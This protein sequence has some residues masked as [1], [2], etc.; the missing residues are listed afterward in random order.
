MWALGATLYQMLVGQ[1]PF[2]GGSHEE[3]VANALALNYA[4]PD[5]LS[6]EARQL[7]DSTLQVLPSDRA[8]LD[9]L[10]KDP[11][12]IAEA[13][14]PPDAPSVLVECDVA[15]SQPKAAV[16]TCHLARARQIAV[17]A[18]YAVLLVGALMYGAAQD[19]GGIELDATS[20]PDLRS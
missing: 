17:Y 2:V 11:W 5:T 13:P 3:L 15:H 20:D 7:M 12:T 14:M 19:H 4:L 16:A 9:E 8:S 6:L 18:V 1:V 10:C